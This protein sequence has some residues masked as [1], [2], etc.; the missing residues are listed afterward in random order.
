MSC[1]CAGAQGTIDGY[2]LNANCVDEPLS[3]LLKTNNPTCQVSSYVGG[4]AC[5]RHGT[6]LLDAAQES[7]RPKHV[8][9]VFFKFRF[10][11]ENVTTTQ[12]VKPVYH[13]EWAGNG[14]DSGLTGTNSHHCTHIEFDVT[15]SKNDT[16]TFKSDFLAEW[17][18]GDTCENTSPQC[19]D[20]SQLG[21]SGKIELV[22]AAAHCHA[23]NCLH[24]ELIRTDTNEVLCRAT[25]V[26]GHTENVFD[27]RG[28]LSTPPCAWSHDP[29]DGLPVPPQLAMNT[30]LR[31]STTFNS[32]YYHAG[33]M[34]IWQMKASFA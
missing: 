30:P 13:V 28:Y 14:C 17:M 19:M 11:Y 16:Q 10:Y 29:N 1:L 32:T 4:L 18:L 27:E 6:I 8:D 31:M 21:P 26:H 25:P 12:D 3:D 2:P 7:T 15:T 20:K 34:S 23:P 22:M 33:Q 5:C 24:Q 9:S